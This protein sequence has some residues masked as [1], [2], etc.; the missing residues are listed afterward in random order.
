MQEGGVMK[1]IIMT[2]IMASVPL[3]FAYA[4]DLQRSVELSHPVRSPY[5]AVLSSAVDNLPEGFTTV[6]VGH[7]IYYYSKGIFYQKIMHDQKY[8]V[9]SPP[10]GAVVSKMPEGYKYL[11]VDGKYYYEYQG[12]YY[13]RVFHGYKVINP[14]V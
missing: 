2:I 7:E 14:P 5:P 3:A 8:M 6:N 10:V 13:K 12:V 11:S 4:S 9:V 1:K